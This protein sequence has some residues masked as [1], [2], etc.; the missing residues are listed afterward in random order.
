[1]GTC[2]RNC[3]GNAGRNFLGFLLD[4]RP[5]LVYY[6]PKGGIVYASDLGS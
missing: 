2:K 6:Y 3:G 4:I 1:M 5:I